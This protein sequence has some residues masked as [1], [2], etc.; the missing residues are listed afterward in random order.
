MFKMRKLKF[1]EAKDNECQVTELARLSED[2]NSSQKETQPM[3]LSCQYHCCLTSCVAMNFWEMEL[4]KEASELEFD[5]ENHL[6]ILNIIYP[7][8]F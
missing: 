4:R 3:L 2:L 8:V 1:R 5:F 7:S 6:C